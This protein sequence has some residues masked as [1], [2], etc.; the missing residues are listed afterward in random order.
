VTEA[1]PGDPPTQRPM[2]VRRRGVGP[3]SLRQVTI[4]ILAMMGAAIIGTL[5]TRP[6]GSIPI[7]LPVPDPSAY[8]IGSPIPG[9]HVGDLAPELEGESADG[10]VVLTDLHGTPIRLAD[11][12]GKVVW[13]N[14]W[15][16]W[17][18]PCQF[19]TPTVRA[20]D[21]RY[22]DRGLAVVAVQVQ[23]TVETGLDY[24]SRY[25]LDYTIGADV[26][27]AIFHAYK[28]FALPTQFFIDPNGVI[29]QIVNGPLDEAR[30]AQ[31]I[32]SL[33]PPGPAG[34]GGATPAPLPSRT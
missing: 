12:R 22:R 33:L 25:G 30:A 16:S 13:I 23:Q 11:L 18:P 17:C 4:A 20:V 14:F 32:E 1:N 10:H 21:Q 8:L 9:L 29:R 7:G 24:A 2:P 27:G 15:A 31:L 28:V 19:E 26:T 3:F 5:A 6:L 34:T